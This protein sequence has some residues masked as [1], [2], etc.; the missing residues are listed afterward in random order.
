[1]NGHDRTQDFAPTGEE[2]HRERQAAEVAALTE[3]QWREQEEQ[4]HGDH[5][6][7]Q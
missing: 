3:R 6:N 7:G 1:M 2:E 5:R 4:K